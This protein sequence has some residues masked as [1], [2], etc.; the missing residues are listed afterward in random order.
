[1][2]IN[3][4]VDIYKQEDSLT[5][6]SNEPLTIGSTAVRLFCK[7][8]KEKLKESGIIKIISKLKTERI[9]ILEPEK[10]LGEINK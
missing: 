1:M 9:E 3:K 4:F 8:N 5:L 6:T 10:L 7:E 2:T